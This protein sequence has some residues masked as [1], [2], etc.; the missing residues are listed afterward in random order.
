[1]LISKAE[2]ARRRDVSPARVSQWISEGKISGA[3]IVGEGRFAQIDE[4]IACGQL[5]VKLDIDQ[6]L[7]G[8]GLKTRLDFD[9]PPDDDSQPTKPMGTT[10]ERQ[11]AE[12][13]LEGLQ[14]QNRKAALEEAQELADLVSAAT[15][16]Q[17]T[18]RELNQ[19]I[20]RFEGSLAELANG[21][22]AQFKLPQRDV[23]HFLKGKWREIRASASLEAR[24]RA[25]PMPESVGYDVGE[26]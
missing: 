26:A 17:A 4:Q 13:R 24:E 18:S 21:M 7:S 6:R 23:L 11:I 8:N 12:Q 20:V 5:N 15:A 2:F 16:R 14:R 25:E 22:A 1:M 10:V 9:A 3:A 19:V